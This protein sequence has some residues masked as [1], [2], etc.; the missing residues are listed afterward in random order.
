MNVLGPD[1]N[2]SY[3]KFTV[4]KQGAIRFGMAGIKSVGGGAVDAIIKEREQ[5]E[6]PLRLEE[7][8]SA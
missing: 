4:N 8:V 3:E 1:V 5:I 6:E 7:E 2:E